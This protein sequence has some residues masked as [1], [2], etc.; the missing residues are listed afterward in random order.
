ML[1]WSWI[2]HFCW[3]VFLFA[4]VFFLFEVVFSLFVIV[5]FHFAFMFFFLQLC[6]CFA[7]VFCDLWL[8]FTFCSC[9]FIWRLWLALQGNH[10]RGFALIHQSHT[11]TNKLMMEAETQCSVSWNCCFSER[12]LEGLSR[13]GRYGFGAEMEAKAGKSSKCTVHS[14]NVDFFC[15]FCPQRY[16]AQL[17]PSELLLLLLTWGADLHPWQENNLMQLY[18]KNLNI[19]SAAKWILE[20]FL[21]TSVLQVCVWLCPVSTWSKILS[22]KTI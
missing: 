20:I 21:S 6:F 17:P 12:S 11:D 22:P 15:C 9:V 10:V 18:S 14:T 13:G 1:A 16:M 5:F 19:P 8:C 3:C 2:Q 7:V 4:V